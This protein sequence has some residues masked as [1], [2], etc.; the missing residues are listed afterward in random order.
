MRHGAR[1]RLQGKPEPAARA[2]QCAEVASGT[3]SRGCERGRLDAGLDL[4]GLH[5]PLERRLHP[6]VGAPA[7]APPSELFFTTT[8]C[9]THAHQDRLPICVA[10]FLN[11]CLTVCGA[12]DFFISANV[13]THTLEI[14]LYS[15]QSLHGYSEVLASTPLSSAARDV[16]SSTWTYSWYCSQRPRR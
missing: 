7:R 8:Y 4:V 3:R 15:D 5:R 11:R 14:Q 2:S 1:T 6:L 13:W 10:Q 12:R 16:H 9:S